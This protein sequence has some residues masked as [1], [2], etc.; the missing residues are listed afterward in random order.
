MFYH[1][2]IAVIC[3]AALA[4]VACE[5]GQT[6]PSLN[7]IEVEQRTSMMNGSFLDPLD[8]ALRTSGEVLS[9]DEALTA[10]KSGAFGPD[11]EPL[12]HPEEL[13][14]FLGTLFIEPSVSPAVVALGPDVRLGHAYYAINSE[15][16]ITCALPTGGVPTSD[17]QRPTPSPPG[18]CKWEVHLDATTGEVLGMTVAPACPEFPPPRT[19]R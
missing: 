16:R 18:P 14:F 11:A 4:L 3:L 13:R 17:S 15:R 2:P 5:S 6:K 1:V 9:P 10:A 19:C 12:D 8:S 7:V